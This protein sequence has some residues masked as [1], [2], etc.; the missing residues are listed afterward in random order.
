MEVLLSKLSYRLYEMESYC[1]SY[2]TF[3]LDSLIDIKEGLDW[4]KDASAD[5]SYLVQLEP[6]L[7]QLTQFVSYLQ[8]R[9]SPF[10]PD[11]RDLFLEF[12]DIVRQLVLEQG[13][14]ASAGFHLATKKEQ[15]AQLIE[16]IQQERAD[17]IQPGRELNQFEARLEQDDEAWLSIVMDFIE[18][19]SRVGEYTFDGILTYKSDANTKNIGQLNQA[20]LASILTIS[21]KTAQSLAWMRCHFNHFKWFVSTQGV[22]SKAKDLRPVFD[23]LRQAKMLIH[24]QDQKYFAYRSSYQAL[25]AAYLTTQTKS[26]ANVAAQLTDKLGLPVFVLPTQSDLSVSDLEVSIL[27]DDIFSLFGSLSVLSHQ[28]FTLFSQDVSGCSKL[29]VISGLLDAGSERYLQRGS[30]YSGRD[31]VFSASYGLSVLGFKVWLSSTSDGLICIPDDKLHSI[32]K[33]DDRALDLTQSYISMVLEGVG[34]VDVFIGNNEIL[35]SKIEKNVILINDLGVTYGI[36]VGAVSVRYQAYKVP[37]FGLK[38]YI[39]MLWYLDRVGVVAEINPLALIQAKSEPVEPPSDT[40]DLEG[41]QGWIVKIA[42]KT[43][44]IHPEVVERHLTADK[45]E[46]VALSYVDLPFIQLEGRCY[47]YFDFAKGSALSLLLLAWQGDSFCLSVSSIYY[48]K[49][50]K[51]LLLKVEIIERLTFFDLSLIDEKNNE[52]VLYVIDTKSF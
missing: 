45:V 16:K 52:N 37:S 48:Q 38:P 19:F 4:L 49:N 24:K 46:R 10:S 25:E 6:L 17:I 18:R 44:F 31:L 21:V 34:L 14:Y 8:Q 2:E 43:C 9:L 15:I 26:L 29:I 36:L 30:E 28:V 3:P 32:H 50:V 27:L 13:F 7:I 42:G 47:P 39:N 22:S 5:L 1:L 23:A 11:Y 12:I 33:W 20:G 35:D 51:S 40:P 41:E